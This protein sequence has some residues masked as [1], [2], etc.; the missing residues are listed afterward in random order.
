MVAAIAVSQALPIYTFN[1]KDFAATG[2]ELVDLNEQA[3]HPTP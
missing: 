3:E 1:P 2:A